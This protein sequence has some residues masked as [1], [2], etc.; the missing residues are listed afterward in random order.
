MQCCQL[1]LSTIDLTRT[2]WWYQR[3]LGF[4]AAGE[5]RERGGPDFAAVPGL[6]EAALEVWCLVG[7]QPF[8]QIEMIQ[9][10]RPI[11]RRQRKSWRRCDIGYS[12]VG[13]Y[14]GD[15]DAAVDCIHRV[16]GEFITEPIGER[17]YRRICLL[18]PDHTL[19]ELME[20][21]LIGEMPVPQE[22]QALPRVACVSLSVRSIGRA[23]PFWVDVL[24]CERVT[25][26]L[27]HTAD[28]ERLWGLGSAIRETAVV[29]TGD[30]FLEFAQYSRP[31]SR[32]RP[33]GYM[34]SDQGIL[35]VA[36]GTT[37]RSEFDDVYRRAVVHGFRG[38]VEPWTVPGVAT[39]V[40]LTDPQG[41]SVE[42]LHVHPDAM[43]RM[44]F[45]RND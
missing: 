40:Y 31:Q 33:A 1:A 7:R 6:P 20:D 22:R 19:V 35:N 16:G 8:M 2:H 37:D 17:G 44:G 34:L 24:G 29:R 3:A 9:F 42:L 41:F 18:D 11:M 28:H 26:T 15:F 45:V 38:H 5:R 14:V 30:V 23:L 32:D 12:T 27:V 25:D 10:T 43:T 36:L 21:S 39:V 13:I 4:A